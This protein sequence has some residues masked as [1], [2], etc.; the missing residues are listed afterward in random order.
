MPLRNAGAG[1]A[2]I[3]GADLALRG[4]EIGQPGVRS[5]P[6]N[7]PPKEFG[8]VRFRAKPGD[9]AFSMLREIIDYVQDFSVEVAYSD[10]AGQQLATTR[11]DVYHCSGTR[12]AVRQIHLQEPDADES[13]AS[14]GPVF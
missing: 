9:A 14:S 13:F 4:P 6:P 11:F 8:R 5:D 1:L 12:W 10:L 2:M 3:R 7:V